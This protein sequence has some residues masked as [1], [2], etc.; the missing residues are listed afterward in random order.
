M[1]ADFLA[2]AAPY[3]SAVFAVVLAVRWFVDNRK[4]RRLEQ[5][6][7]TKPERELAPGEQP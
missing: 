7:P 4:Q 6:K 2:L 1:I 3:A 5:E